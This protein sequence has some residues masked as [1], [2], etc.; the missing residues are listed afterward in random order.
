MEQCRV[1][2]FFWVINLLDSEGYRSNVGI[3]IANSNDQLLWA[4]RTGDNAWQFPQGGVKS[5][6]SV[7][8]AMFREL[9]EEVGLKP[10]DVEV[11]DSTQGWLK[12][13]FPENLIRKD[14]FPVCIGQKQCW[15]LLRLVSDDSAVVLNLS[16]EPE[17]DAWCW[18]EYWYPVN[19][20]VEFKREVYQQ[21]LEIL[22]E[23]LDMGIAK[24]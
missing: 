16:D 22:E 12:Y 3:I 4:R 9:N 23:S 13:E 10:C 11:I 7:F 17:F 21:A 6:E 1:E 14:L 15:F 18:V 20:V 24:K 19:E 8:D 2:I 5:G